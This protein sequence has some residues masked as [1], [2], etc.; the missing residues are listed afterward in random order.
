MAD[1]NLAVSGLVTP[2]WWAGEKPLPDAV[3]HALTRQ[4]HRERWK[5]TQCNKVVDMVRA[6]QVRDS[7]PDAS[8]IDNPISVGIDPDRLLIDAPEALIALASGPMQ[9]LVIEKDSRV[10]LQWTHER[11]SHPLLVRIERG[12]ELDLTEVFHSGEAAF[13]H[14]WLVLETGAIVR[15]SRNTLHEAGNTGS[16]Q[17]QALFVDLAA[18]AQYA[19][20]NH[21]SGNLLN[22]QDIQ[23]RC[24]GRGAHA[25]ID[26]SACV[27][28]ARHL[29]QQFTLEHIDGHNSSEQNIHTIVAA[30]AK[31]TFNG[32][33]H[34]HAQAP[35]TAAH[36]SNRNLCLADATVNTK[37]ELE[38]Y[39]DDVQCS[40]GATIGRLDE[41]QAF[42]CASRGIEPGAARLLLSK[43]FLQQTTTGPLA[44]AALDNYD[45]VLQA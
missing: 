44:E 4:R 16:T 38:I 8:D 13:Q 31:V 23:I 42:Y 14:L 12:A 40:H 20:H 35:G 1:V 27:G 33:I 29:D 7:V 41:G 6:T 10:S 28:P 25:R 9:H 18:D 2:A 34:I 32:R 15:H 26:A 45:Q 36:L 5:Y 21:C 43:A 30:K 24:L 17:W 11:S 19:L 22:R 3:S 39:T 37:P